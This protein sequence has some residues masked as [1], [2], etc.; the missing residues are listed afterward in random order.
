MNDVLV[1]DDIEMKWN[2]EMMDEIAKQIG[3][4]YLS[5]STPNE[6]LLET[7]FPPILGILYGHHCQP[8]VSLIIGSKTYE[9][10]LQ[11]VFL[12]DPHRSCSY[13]SEK[14]MIALGFQDGYTPNTEEIWFRDSAY[15]MYKSPYGGILQEVNVLGSD[16]LK[17]CR[18]TVHLDYLRH[19]VTLITS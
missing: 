17:N 12:I 14:T 19:E 3:T 4:D 5:L 16:F 13:I 2:E 10:F 7:S 1:Y 18:S 15:L 6:N 9:K 11:V 8:F